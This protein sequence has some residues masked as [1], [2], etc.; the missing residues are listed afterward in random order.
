[1]DIDYEYLFEKE[2]NYIFAYKNKLIDYLTK[3]EYYIYD[4]LTL[5]INLC[6]FYLLNN[7]SFK[8]LPLF[9]IDKEEYNF[10]NYEYTVNNQILGKDD[11]DIFMNKFKE[12]IFI[13]FNFFISS[14][15]DFK[16][17][18]INKYIDERY[19]GYIYIKKENTIYIFFSIIED[20][21]ENSNILEFSK[22]ILL[23]NKK[24]DWLLMHQIIKHTP[25][26]LFHIFPEIYFTFSKYK[27]YILCY[28]NGKRENH[29][30][31]GFFYY[32]VYKNNNLLN[33]EEEEEKKEKYILNV[34]TKIYLDI[35]KYKK[36]IKK[37]LIK[38]LKY[39]A[40]WFKEENEIKICIKDYKNFIKY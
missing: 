3:K 26:S 22:E 31:F 37:L 13:L 9:L 12:E 19:K 21:R 28:G 8:N 34:E 29:P 33:T 23:D 25:L 4:G 35:K 10:P 32:F 1:M 18:D 30:Y 15:N 40:F 27:N 7:N 2:V 20:F 38:S 6:I 17:K 5:N 24:Y 11:N 16:K 14:L 36:N 39:D